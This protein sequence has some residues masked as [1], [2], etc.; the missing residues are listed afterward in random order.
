MNLCLF[1]L[2]HT[3]LPLDSDHSW[4]EFMVR[5]GWA[6]AVEHRAGNEAF[7]AQYQAG[8]LDVAAYIDF[9]TRPWRERPALELTQVRERF[10]RELIEPAIRPSALA[11]VARHREAGDRLAIVTA[12]NE[13]V[14]APIARAFEVDTLIALELERTA[15]G[16]CTGRVTGVPSFREGKVARVEAWLAA[17]GLKLQDFGRVTVY[18]DS[19]NDLPL[20]E[21]ATDPVATNPSPALDAVARERGWRV[22]NLFA[23]T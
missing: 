12:T 11:L 7:Y 4:G 22:L 16:R 3:L 13:F 20:L 23:P 1:D 17:D 19:P 6:D 21:I 14:T 10:M 15:D 5:I 9:A 8:T 18:S 2:D